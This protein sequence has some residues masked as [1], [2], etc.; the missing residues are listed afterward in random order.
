MPIINL[1][2]KENVIVNDNFQ[3]MENDEE[4]IKN[5]NNPDDN[6]EVQES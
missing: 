5:P 1:L 3:N 4:I 6:N 2:G